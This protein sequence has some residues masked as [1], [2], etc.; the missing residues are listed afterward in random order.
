MRNFAKTEAFFRTAADLAAPDVDLLN[1]AAV[2]ARDRGVQLEKA[3]RHAEAVAMLERSHE[4]YVRAVALDPRS[5]RLRNDCAL[6]LVHYLERDWDESKTLLESA[7]ADGERELEANPPANA[8]ELQ[9]LDESVGDCLENLALWHL[10]HDQDFA[11][12]ES[13]ARR[14]LEHYPREK[15]SGARSHLEA[16]QRM[17]AD[18]ASGSGGGGR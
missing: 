15:R 17:R 1:N 7:L 13:A 5:V 6:V 2:Y 8:R 11:A 10:K 12:A 4:T 9:D 14:S 18:P 3:G 16:A